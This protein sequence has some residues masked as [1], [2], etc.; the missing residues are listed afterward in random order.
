MFNCWNMR[1]HQW[2]TL[3]MHQIKVVK[4]NN[5]Y[6]SER[7]LNLQTTKHKLKDS[8]RGQRSEGEKRLL[9]QLQCLRD[10]KVKSKPK[11]HSL[12][13]CFLQVQQWIWAQISLQKII[14]S[15]QTSSSSVQQPEDESVFY[16]KPKKLL[17]TKLHPPGFTLKTR[18]K[19][20]SK[21]ISV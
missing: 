15:V 17:K 16:V 20:P 1:R 11:V 13:I 10:R 8:C 21:N 2:E 3:M 14:D 18:L 7:E 4:E 6:M 19:K 12:K 5:S 9:L